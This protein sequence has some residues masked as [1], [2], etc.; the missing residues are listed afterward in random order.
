MRRCQNLQVLPHNNDLDAEHGTKPSSMSWP[1]LFMRFFEIEG[2]MDTILGLE[3][4]SI[5]NN[6][7]TLS[8]INQPTNELQYKLG[9]LNLS[10]VCCLPQMYPFNYIHLQSLSLIRCHIGKKK[11]SKIPKSSIHITGD[12]RSG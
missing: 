10:F 7:R 11:S 3:P 6:T 12:I 4:V 9:S 5:I 1:E 2:L 8:S